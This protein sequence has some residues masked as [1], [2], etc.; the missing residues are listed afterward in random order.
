MAQPQ[1]GGEPDALAASADGL[2][3]LLQA[4]VPPRKREEVTGADDIFSKLGLARY[5]DAAL[6]L[7]GRGLYSKLQTAAP[8]V[9]YDPPGPAADWQLST[10]PGPG[11]TIPPPPPAAQQPHPDALAAAL[12]LPPGNHVLPEP[13]SFAKDPRPLRR[14]PASGSKVA[15]PLFGCQGEHFAPGRSRLPYD[16]SYAG[17]AWG[18]RE[19]PSRGRARADI[20]KDYGAKGDGITDDTAAFERA[21]RDF[22]GPGPAILDIPAGRFRITRGLEK[23]SGSIVLRG[24]GRDRTKLFFPYSLSQLHGNKFREGGG[25]C[26]SDWSHSGAFIK[27]M[28][29]DAHDG[30]TQLSELRDARRVVHGSWVRLHAADP[31]DN[32]A[33]NAL[34]GYEKGVMVSRSARILGSYG[35][36]RFFTR[37]TEVKGDMVTLERPLPFPVKRRWR[38]T[39]HRVKIRME[40]CGV[41]DL[42]I[43]FPASHYPAHLKEPGYNAIFY[44]MT[45][46]SWIK[47]VRILNADS[48]VYMWGA[49]ATTID[50]LEVGTT[51]DRGKHGAGHRAV[52]MEHGADNLLTR[53]NISGVYK[54]DI[55]FSS[56][57]QGSVASAGSGAD[58]NIDFHRS[59]PYGNL[60]TNCN[61]GAG[62]RAF[63][64][65]G[66]PH[67]GPHA[68]AV[69][70]L[71][72]LSAPRGKALALPLNFVFVSGSHKNAPKPL[73]WGWLHQTHSW[74]QQFPLDLHAALR[75]R[76]VAA[77][78][79]SA[80]VPMPGDA[81]APAPAPPVGAPLPG[82]AL[83]P[84]AAAA[85]AR[86]DFG[87]SQD[88]REFSEFER[89]PVDDIPWDELPGGGF[90][91]ELA[92]P[93]PPPP[94]Q[95]QVRLRAPRAAAAREFS[96]FERE[97]V[98]DFNWED[99]P[100]GGLAGELSLP[101]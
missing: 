86:G 69:N 12:T 80:A 48:A 16:W 96:E 44:R 26:S 41:Q 50:G 35:V 23:W 77:A 55:S 64:G 4:S 75:R 54:H 24:A 97:P 22:T 59:A 46:H 2:R 52:W 79:A 6:N 19:V 53:F 43:E 78:A 37:V 87:D 3:A 63:M 34:L 60:V 93:P 36:L 76:R 30:S 66:A 89:E 39:L 25:C 31:G 73:P 68:G 49:V 7:R 82:D 13:C 14:C 88:G 62:T 74:R 27:F 10:L 45:G 65:S 90:A 85:A 5:R 100:G 32:D 11:T 15:S 40:Q 28:S 56:F 58:L 20:V 51:S 9:L 21:F 101:Q 1:Q 99:L 33:T 67:N 70:T 38:P 83:G 61:F 84:A 29:M 42:T 57:E 72:G 18:E 98:D 8:P 92:L 17:Y 81:L 47:N 94:P 95:K 71:W 91:G